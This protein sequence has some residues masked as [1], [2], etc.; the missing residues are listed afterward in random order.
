MK[1]NRRTFFRQT[2]AAG[3]L[4]VVL[5]AEAND[6]LAQEDCT[7]PNPPPA[8][9][10]VPDEKR[11]LT[12]YSAAELATQSA[13]LAT[14]RKATG[15][16]RALPANDV[17]SWTKQVAQHCIQC[18]SSNTS[19]IHYD[20]QFLPWH[21]ALLYF[22]ERIMRKL[23]ASDDLRL[24]YWNWES[25][26]SRRPPDIY[27]PSGQPLYWANRGNLNGNTWPLPDDKV[28]VQGAL[29][30]P[31]FDLFGGTRVQR[32]PVPIA[33]TGPHANVHNNF[34]PNGDM[35]N[36]Q[37]SPRDPV[38]FAHHGNIDRLWTSWVAAGHNNVDFGDAKVYFYDDTRTWRYVLMN[39]L[40]DESKLGY[41]YSSLMQL[42]Q[43]GKQLN[44]FSASRSGGFLSLPAPATATLTAQPV[45]P[46]FLLITNIAL[47]GMPPDSRTFGVFSD[48]PAPGVD[49][50]SD[51]GFLGITSRVLSA[52]HNHDDSLSAALNLTRRAP[53]LAP[54]VR[55]QLQL[56]VVAL[57]DTEKTTAAS[58]PLAADNVSLIE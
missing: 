14:F 56:R 43:P 36:L 1:T 34:A 17:N 10:Y 46:R 15:A 44:A 39:D 50:R 33:Y 38:F 41:K 28:D 19:N 8:T 40:R 52:G 22:M 20:W 51:P 3:P 27:L 58:I 12:R 5:L 16:V 6:A 57:D 55:G 49:A 26:S 2:L 18:A 32:Q 42:E 35:R 53:A 21:R 29:A 24:C 4:S 30:T 37:Y 25:P 45:A 7:L 48:Q 31:S 11:V 9:R 54:A 13:A 47:T 23:S